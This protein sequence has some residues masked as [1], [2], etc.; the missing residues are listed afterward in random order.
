MRRILITSLLLSPMLFTASAVA[1]H[2]GTDAAAP[3]QDLRISTGVI[4]PIVLSSTTI[5]P[6]S[7]SLL[8]PDNAKVGLTMKVDAQGRPNDIQVI[9]PV[10]PFLDKRV[11]DAVSKFRFHPAMLDQQAIPVDMNLTVEVKK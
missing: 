6:L 7:Y 11:V 1:S 4:A 9:K 2:P 5:D 10:N 3:T 8:I